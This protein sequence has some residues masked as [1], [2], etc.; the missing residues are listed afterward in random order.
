MIEM[1]VVVACYWAYNSHQY[2]DCAPLKPCGFLIAKSSMAGGCLMAETNPFI[3]FYIILHPKWHNYVGTRYDLLVSLNSSD[4]LGLLPPPLKS[5]PF[6]RTVSSPC[7]SRKRHQAYPRSC[8]P[9]W[10]PGCLRSWCPVGPS[11]RPRRG[12]RC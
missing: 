9:W 6:P 10:A 4:H 8:G 11:C 12:G 7:R 2:M 1:V 3:T 5:M